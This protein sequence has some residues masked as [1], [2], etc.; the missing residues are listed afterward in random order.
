MSEVVDHGRQWDVRSVED[1]LPDGW[2]L[3]PTLELS[4]FHPLTV[5]HV[6][7]VIR[8]GAHQLAS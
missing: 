3:L 5:E 6:A 7:A 1:Y 8:H 2:I 4:D